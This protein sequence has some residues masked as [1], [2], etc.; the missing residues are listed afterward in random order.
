MSAALDID[1]SSAE[2]W[3]LLRDL[4]LSV[5]EINRGDKLSERDVRLAAAEVGSH[6]GVPTDDVIM[7]FLP[8]R[9][10]PVS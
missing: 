5:I 2:Y 1:R 9:K 8:A 3:E 7:A 4:C 10:P 6:L